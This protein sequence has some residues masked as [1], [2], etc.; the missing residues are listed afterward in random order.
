MGGETMHRSVPTLVIRVLPCPGS[1]VYSACQDDQSS[2]LAS[3]DAVVVVVPP[4]A[5]QPPVFLVDS[6]YISLSL[7]PSCSYVL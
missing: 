1:M 4:G 3:F 2:I 7:C 6:G 5:W